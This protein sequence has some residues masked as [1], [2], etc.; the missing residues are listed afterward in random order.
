MG[1]K[2]IPT[3]YFPHSRFWSLEIIHTEKRH[4]DPF[5]CFNDAIKCPSHQTWIAGTVLKGVVLYLSWTGIF[6]LSSY[7]S[8]SGYANERKNYKLCIV[9]C[10]T[11]SEPL[12]PLNLVKQNGWPASINHAGHWRGKRRMRVQS[13]AEKAEQASSL[14]GLWWRSRDEKEGVGYKDL[15]AKDEREILLDSV[16]AWEGKVTHGI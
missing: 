11:D 1:H 12:E 13:G 8:T 16:S 6:F 9:P 14:V 15:E 2:K 4:E 7:I 10:R 5:S 3:L